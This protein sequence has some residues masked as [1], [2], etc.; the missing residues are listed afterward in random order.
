MSWLQPLVLHATREYTTISHFL[1]PGPGRDDDLA[2]Q[3]R[4]LVLGMSAHP[5]SAS[6]FCAMDPCSASAPRRL[7]D[8][9]TSHVSTTAPHDHVYEQ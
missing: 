8:S 6:M 1:P 7:A 2:E 5:H 9:Y 3:R 4:A